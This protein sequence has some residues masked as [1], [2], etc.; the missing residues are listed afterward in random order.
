MHEIAANIPCHGGVG[1]GPD[2]PDRGASDLSSPALF[3][4]THITGTAAM[5][6]VLSREQSALV[7]AAARLQYEHFRS[8]IMQWSEKHQTVLGFRPTEPLMRKWILSHICTN[9][10]LFDAKQRDPTMKS[11]NSEQMINISCITNG[12]SCS[13]GKALPSRRVRSVCC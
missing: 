7:N 12:N 1:A 8:H 6:A 9:P 10:D 5:A 11:P 13:S 3:A 2:R 4:L